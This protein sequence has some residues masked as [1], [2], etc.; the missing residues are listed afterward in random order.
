MTRIETFILLYV[1]SCA[2]MHSTQRATEIEMST[3]ISLEGGAKF[4]TASANNG[5]LIVRCNS[6]LTDLKDEESIDS[7]ISRHNGP[8]EA[9]I[10]LQKCYANK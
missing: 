3:R 9:A 8:D 1:F 10:Y 4:V 7:F 6:N 2:V 5:A